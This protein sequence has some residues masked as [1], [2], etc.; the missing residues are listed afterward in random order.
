MGAGL[1]ISRGEEMG[2]DVGLEDDEG[3]GIADL[4]EGVTELGQ[5]GRQILYFGLD[6]LL[7]PHLAIETGLFFL[8]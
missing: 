3:P 6:L 8:F 2:L 4:E 1:E 7:Q 5:V